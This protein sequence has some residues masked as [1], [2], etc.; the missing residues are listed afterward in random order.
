MVGGRSGLPCE[1]GIDRG[2]EPA[3]TVPRTHPLGQVTQPIVTPRVSARVVASDWNDSVLEVTQAGPTDPSPPPRGTGNEAVARVVQSID[4]GVPPVARHPAEPAALEAAVFTGLADPARFVT[5]ARLPATA[6]TTVAA[7]LYERVWPRPRRKPMPRK[8]RLVGGL[9][10]SL[11]LGIAVGAL[12]PPRS[13][14][15]VAASPAP[16]ARA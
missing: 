3:P 5:S 6:L 13:V 14:E 7:F 4:R 10:L 15:R 8:Y 2:A 16:T 1:S 9:L 12:L 11:G